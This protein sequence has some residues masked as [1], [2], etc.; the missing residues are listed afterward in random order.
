MNNANDRA[1]PVPENFAEPGLTKREY[2][3]AMAMQGIAAHPN[4]AIIDAVAEQ[5]GVRA[6]D[7]M[8]RLAVLYADALL[9]ALEK[10]R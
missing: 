5:E 2:F 8:A 1:F 7:A 3:A 9:R 4:N 10:E 6:S